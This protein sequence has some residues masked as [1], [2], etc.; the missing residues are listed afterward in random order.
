MLTNL[1]DVPRTKR[2]YDANWNINGR[3]PTRW[4]KTK[5]L[6]EYHLFSCC[7]RKW[8]WFSSC[9]NGQTWTWSLN[10]F[11]IDVLR[12]ITKFNHCYFRNLLSSYRANRQ[13]LNIYR[14]LENS[15]L[16][17]VLIQIYIY[18]IYFQLLFTRE[19]TSN[20]SQIFL[21]N[22]QIVVMLV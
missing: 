8:C 9:G 14:Y 13:F 17:L 19:I 1:T 18:I 4:Q 20:Y 16:L 6:P 22:C 2:T 12:K 21:N 11:F 5:L 7:N 3:L 15:M 10:C